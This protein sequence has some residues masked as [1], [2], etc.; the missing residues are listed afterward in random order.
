[1]VLY[2]S[3]EHTTQSYLMNKGLYQLYLNKVALYYLI[4][5]IS[6]CRNLCWVRF[7]RKIKIFRKHVSRDFASY[8][9]LTCLKAN[10][11]SQLTSGL[12]EPVGI[13]S[14]GDNVKAIYIGPR[15]ISCL[16]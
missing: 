8:R 13:F 10:Y 5:G 2:R 12:R 7:S 14:S 6:S 16:D 15:A 3:L 1:M 11:K 4:E 9:E